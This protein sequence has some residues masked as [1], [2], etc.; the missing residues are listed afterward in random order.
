MKADGKHR[1]PASSP[2]CRWCPR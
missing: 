2:T 1:L